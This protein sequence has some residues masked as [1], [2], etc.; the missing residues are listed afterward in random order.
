M[1]DERLGE[2]IREFLKSIDWDDVAKSNKTL[3]T[4]IRHIVDY[5]TSVA[6]EEFVVKKF[7]TGF[8]VQEF[9]PVSGKF[10]CQSFVSSDD[11]HYEDDEGNP[12][13]P[14][15]DYLPFYMKQP[16]EIEVEE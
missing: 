11:V 4:S 15:E 5:V 8:V 6:D 2:E 14:F 1:T 7:T 12:I 13:E 3:P 9:N 16:S 10:I